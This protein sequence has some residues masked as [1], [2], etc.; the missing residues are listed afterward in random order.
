MAGGKMSARQKMINLMYIVLMA[1][2]ALNVSKDIL[3]AFVI[4]DKGIN[5]TLVTFEEKNQYLYDKFYKANIDNPVKVEPWLK[6]AN[7]LK[8][9]SNDLVAYIENLKRHLYKTVE[10][11]SQEMADTLFLSQV[12][13]KDDYDV[14][15]H[16]LIGSDPGNPEEV[17]TPLW[18]SKKRY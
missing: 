8:S 13:K 12:E 17:N 15:T 11:I 5:E 1:L 10:G 2:L 18:S 7:E 3:D 16:I 4:L 14:P 9:I 6:K